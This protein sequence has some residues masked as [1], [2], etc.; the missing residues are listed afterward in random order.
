MSTDSPVTVPVAPARNT[1]AAPYKN[2]CHGLGTDGDE[3]Q[4]IFA[5]GAAVMRFVRQWG[6]NP[7]RITGV[8]CNGQVRT[9]IVVASEDLLHDRMPVASRENIEKLKRGL[10]T[11]S[12]PSWYT[13]PAANNCYRASWKW[14]MQSQCSPLLVDPSSQS[15]GEFDFFSILK[16]AGTTSLHKLFPATTVQSNFDRVVILIHLVGINVG[17]ILAPLVWQ[18]RSPFRSYADPAVSLSITLIIFATII[19]TSAFS[20]VGGAHWK[21]KQ[22]S[23]K[24]DLPALPDVLAVHNLHVFLPCKSP[25]FASLRICVPPG[26]TLEQW[27]HT[28][29]G[30]RG[31]FLS[32]R[33]THVATS[34]QHFC[35]NAA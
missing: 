10:G 3:Q 14:T 11:N 29:G 17:V 21:S 33:V 13:H 24:I 4:Q 12:E 18:L 15:F 20:W 19:P 9:C 26:M 2:F 16:D 35:G 5:A 32:H 1:V 28:Q 8:W 22:A 25:I 7:C 31:C 6:V 27:E 34:P 30:V 23:Q